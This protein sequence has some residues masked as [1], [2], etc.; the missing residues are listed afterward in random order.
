MSK[1][2]I[3]RP[4]FAIVIS[5][6]ILILGTLAILSLPVAQYPKI[7]QPTI[8]VSTSYR[9][10]NSTVINQTVAQVIEQK[11]NGTQGMD[12]MTSSSSDN[13]SYS[14][15]VYF[16]L[17]SNGDMDAV[18]V[19]NNVSIATASLPS[20]V[21]DA[22]VTTKKASG[23]MAYLFA[24]YS[25]NATFNRTFISNYANIYLVDALKRIKGVGD[26]TSF[27][28]DHSIRI[29]LN[30]ERLASLNLTIND[31]RSA[32]SEQNKQAP[33]GTIGTLPVPNN[34]EKQYT[35]T[36]EGRISTIEE[37]GNVVLKTTSE[38]V[39]IYLR[40]VAK[41]ET[42]ARSA[43]MLTDT[44]DAPS[45]GFGINLTDD[46]NAIE[47]IGEVKRVIEEMSQ[48]FPDD[49]VYCPIIDNTEYIN[50]SLA[51]VLNTFKEALILVIVIVFIFL[52]S[53]R[54]T[55]IPILA[56]PVSLVG[57]FAT[58]TILG[59]TIN[60]LTLFA[61]VLAIGL[62]V[63]DA[64]VV[65][66]NV[67]H[68]MKKDGLG[69]VEATELAMSEVQGP[70]VAIA[71]VLSA[72]FIPVAF[73]G[74]MTGV[75]YK[76][77]AL[78]IAVSMGLSA[79]VALTLTPALCAMIMK[80]HD[81]NAKKNLLDKFFDKFNDWFER[82]QAKYTGVVGWCVRHLKV[83]VVLLL[84]I[85]VLTGVTYKMLPS[86]F[87]PNEDQGYFLTA[88]SLPEGTSLN[89]TYELMT[90]VSKE[91]S[92]IPGVI[93]VM[94]IAG[95]DVLSGGNKSNAGAIFVGLSS[96]DERTTKELSLNNIIREVNKLSVRHPEATMMAMA[97]P[98][99]PGLGMVGG[100]SMELL[101][102]T[103]YSNEELDTITKRI[104]A[105][106]NQRPELSRV[107]T[108]YSIN[109]PICKFEIN[110]EKAKQLGVSFSD[111]YTALQVNFGG[112]QIGDFMQFGRSYKIV[113]QSDAQYRSEAE[114]LKFSYVKN[115]Q[116]TMVPLDSLV[117]S[118]YGTSTAIISRFN[119][120]RS[121]TIQG[122]TASGYSSGQAIQAMEEVVHEI[123]PTGFSIEWS[124]QSREEKKTSGSTMQV[125]GLALVFVFLCLAALYESWSVP[126]A[127]LLTVPTGIFGAFFVQYALFMGLAIMGSP[128]P[129]LQ[130]SV[131][132][133]IG[134]IM[135]M[136]LAA[137]NAILIVEFAKVRTDKGMDAIQ[138]AIEAANLRLRPILM[139]SLAFIIGCLPLAMASGAGSA[140][141][142]GMGTAVVGGMLFA[143]SLGIF[144]I[145]IFFV[146]VET[147]VSKIKGK[148]QT[149]EAISKTIEKGSD[150]N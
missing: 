112:S 108:T 34:Q 131:Y 22:G 30:P 105:A 46:A 81:P 61:M 5:I 65:I 25:P 24:M 42:G 54:A 97:T 116:G 123:V 86:T 100:W 144:L 2:F 13:G 94:K 74:G 73:L 14:L 49:L 137:K 136:G 84:I 9:G 101:D 69:A 76:Q 33:A 88:I 48:N 126:F 114:A 75:L 145:P 4:I 52:Q 28:M 16:D 115:N 142:N 87:V 43:T 146:V 95:Y 119:G 133:Q 1:F 41:I 135:I 55:L 58:F 140:A 104:I 80:P 92:E 96:W 103:G 71:F 77:F 138:A 8:S 45:A 99:L 59:F 36:L 12:Y 139:T 40:D 3:H 89:R 63:D 18:L 78:T 53:W 68:H 107:R 17:N 118:S 85:C 26:V 90:T 125:M 102:M 27:A 64:I 111:V 44:N 62:V 127:V 23:D 110:R 6:I 98:S 129:G 35:G 124:G 120:T 51:E 147:I 109:S 122:S 19:Q 47:T 20:D 141:R 15:R 132:M 106:A 91:I 121:V 29:W 143:T 83:G 31:V 82:T 93:S 39:N 72:V 134:V 113:L 57:T 21:K 66:E 10:A 7:T 60:T 148:S 37:F 11:V 67:E 56:I 79:F 70:V 50:E 32:I 38:G 130:N 149:D 117:T 128:N 150:L